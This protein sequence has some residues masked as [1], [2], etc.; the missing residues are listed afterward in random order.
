MPLS[1]SASGSPTSGPA[2]LTVLFVGG[3]SGGTGPYTFQ[4]SFGDG[5]TSTLQSP[6]NTYT[7][8][9]SFTATLTVTD[10]ASATAT[11]TVSISTGGAT[12]P[13]PPP[14]GDGEFIED[15]TDEFEYSI[16]WSEQYGEE[17]PGGGVNLSLDAGEATLVGLIPF[18]VER[19]AAKYFLGHSW[20][21]ANGPDFALHRSPP[22]MHPKY[23]QLR[24]VGFSAVGHTIA[25]SAADPARPGVKVLYRVSPFEDQLGEPM[26]YAQYQL[27]RCTVKYHSMGR[28]RFLPDSDIELP[29]NEWTR[30]CKFDF[31]PGVEALSADG[32]S[33]LQFAEGPGEFGTGPSVGTAFPAPVA[34][35]YAK[36]SFRL[37]WVNVP[38]RYVSSDPTVPLLDKI[39]PRIGTVNKDDLF[40][41][42]FKSGTMLLLGVAAK[43][44]LFPVA[45]SDPTDYPITGLNL[46]FH[47]QH[48][49]GEKGVSD[50][51]YRGHRLFLWR[52]DGYWYYCT[53]GASGRELVPLMDHMPIFTHQADPAYP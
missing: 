11:A 29:I 16:H 1:A 51:E 14:G 36:S 44:M 45:P 28:M 30:Y 42:K 31:S 46:E 17:Q 53:R 19:S 41:G 9:A 5:N 35:L 24:C 33:Q 50:S 39:L 34:E 15:P 49:D 25:T 7:V 21:S 47:W 26:Y 38:I 37:T 48:L 6:A 32:Q 23:P 18:N 27:S 12:G 4:W 3:A 43:E 13:P 22:A 20:C 8:P 10:A 52:H 40:A 2:P